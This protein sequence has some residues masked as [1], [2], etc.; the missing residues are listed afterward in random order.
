MLKFYNSLTNKIEEF[1]PHN[2]NKVNMYVC[3]PTVYN[4]I[5]IGNARPVVFYDMVKNYLEFLG[6]QVNYASNITD[7]DDKIINK[8]IEE[9]KTEKEIATFYE[10]A[11]FKD[12]KTLG[13]QKPNFIPHATEYINNMIDF[14]ELLKENGYAYQKDGNVYFRINK[15][16]DYGVLSNQDRASLEEGARVDVDLNKEDPLD[17]TL[18]KN[19]KVGIKWPSPFGD[20]RPGWH[21]ECV[22]MN[23]ELFKDGL[24]IHGGGMDLKFPH[25]ENEIAQSNAVYHDHLASY[26]LHVGRVDLKGMKMSKSLGNVIYVKDLKTKEE[27]MVL[28]MLLLFSP[29]RSIINF[30]QELMEQYKTI[31]DKWYRSYKQIYYYLSAHDINSLTLDDD[32][33]TKFKEYM[34]DD[35][36]VQ[37]VLTLIDDLVKKINVSFRNKDES[38]VILFNTFNKILKVLG[39][40]FFLPDLTLEDSSTYLSWEEARKNKDFQKAD[41]FRNILVEKGII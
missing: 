13:S 22:V 31:Y 39:I 32:Y 26:F 25:H 3:G 9:K 29:Y 12:V 36:N 11:Y 14:I 2:P 4:Y 1:K 18:W 38:L 23:H 6:Y 16:T 33:L 37:N 27:A 41:Y 8:A 5:H 21:T 15:I 10:D 7:I 35:F 30:S 34:D 20:G 40:N 19:T 17:F 28:R 24:D